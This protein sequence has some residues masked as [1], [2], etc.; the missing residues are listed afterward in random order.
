MILLLDYEVKNEFRG[1]LDLEPIFDCLGSV[2]LTSVLSKAKSETAVSLGG[3]DE[4]G[5]AK[6]VPEANER[7]LSLGVDMGRDALHR[8]WY[9]SVVQR[10]PS[11]CLA[12]V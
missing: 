8:Y 6:I 12:A 7:L 2:S 1:W 9:Q 5:R 3:E 10:E 11:E 4:I